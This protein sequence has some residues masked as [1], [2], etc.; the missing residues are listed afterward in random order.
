MARQNIPLQEAATTPVQVVLSSLESSPAGLS[1][2]EAQSRVSA[3]GPNVLTQRKE[4]PVFVQ[5]LLEFK[6]PLIIILLIAAGVSVFFG[7]V[8]DATIIVIMVLL[9]VVLD[10][11]QEHSANEAVKRL[12]E[13]VKTT[14]TVIRQGGKQEVATHDLCV[15]DIIFLNAGD[16][17]PAD[18]RIISSTDFFVNQSALT[19]ESFPSGKND[20]TLSST[21]PDGVSPKMYSLGELANIVFLGTSVVSG[22]ATAVVVRKGKDTE[23]GKIADTLV[24]ASPDSEF[25]IGVRNF[26]HLIMR[27]IVFLVLFIFLFNSLVKHQLLESFMFAVAIAVGLTPELLPVIMSVTMA[28]GS[29]HMAKKGV[30][31]KKLSSIPNFG[32]MD[33]LC[34]DK[35]GT[36]T[37]DKITLMKYTDPDG[38]VSERVLFFTYLNSTYQT[39][40][41]NP[42]DKAVLDFRKFPLESYVKVDEIPFDF[43]RKKMSI[44]ADKIAAAQSHTGKRM[45]PRTI[46]RYLITKGAPEE[47]FKSC[48]HTLH[49]GRKHALDEKTITTVTKQYQELSAQGFRVLAIAMKEIPF[50]RGSK[51]GRQRYTKHD[52]QD[53]ELL[54][55]VSFFDPPKADVSATLKEIHAMG[56]EIKIITGDNE[57]VTKKVCSDLGLDVK[58]ILLGEEM[59]H[60]TD[61]A[62]KVRVERTTIFARFTPDEKNRVI[63]ALKANNHVVGYMGDG[64]NDAP[65]L[66]TADVGISVDTAVDIAKE[67]ADIVLTR[68]SLHS[69]KEGIL[70][71]R[72]TFGNTM[73]YILMG[74]SSNFGNM[75]S[76]AGAVIF[77]PFLP[78]LPIQILLN[79]FL[80]D[81]SQVTIASDTVDPE[82]IQRPK[83]WNIHF[84]KRFMMVFGIISSVFDFLT[85]FIMLWVFNA[86]PQVFQTAWFIESLATQTLVIYLIRTKKIPFLQSMPSPLLI[87]STL[88]CV[89]AGWIITYTALGAIFGFTPLPWHVLLAIVALVAIYLVLVEFAKRIFYSHFDANESSF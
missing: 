11:V 14:A 88:A 15:G 59:D 17:V 64:I 28:K 83:R 33:V 27:V 2:F 1:S 51:V 46:A 79:N 52:E 21:L 16:L 42:L 57:L 43:V 26:S 32:S 23:F 50:E 31:V 38:K 48:T 54:G 19:G 65:S 70:D 7:Q 40:I 81:F 3:Y 10:F 80:Y 22:S 34:T 49:N 72:K 8:L 86:S 25:D 82:F 41:S 5:F 74:L 24:A 39:G 6:S 29:V 9:S 67:S 66:R 85:F 37:E 55:F 47:I 13:T 68:K 18:A 61:D 56:I 45:Q 73:K 58:G 60:L 84:I 30:I 75:F 78:M 53:L 20:L 71:G 76:A 62:L 44:V 35:T 4:R 36:L 12:K 89:I 87:V 63:L 69:L 77:L